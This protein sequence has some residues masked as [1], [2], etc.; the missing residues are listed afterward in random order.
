MSDGD[1]GKNLFSFL[2]DLNSGTSE[3]E[4]WVDAG[5]VEQ[6]SAIGLRRMRIGGN[7]VGVLRM[8]DGTFVAR[9]L[10]CKHHGADLSAGEWRG[11]VVVC[12]RHGWEY[13]LAT[14]QCISNPSLPLRAY[15]TKVE[16]GHLWVSL[17]RS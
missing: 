10:T 15:A 5:S 11:T 14:G 7:P 17:K 16:G 9:E 13:D 1:G 4:Q 6:L 3:V 8:A 2:D 12:P